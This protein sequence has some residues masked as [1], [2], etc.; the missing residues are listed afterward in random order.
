MN[1]CLE[2]LTYYFIDDKHF[3]LHSVYYKFK[4]GPYL[5]SFFTFFFRTIT[6]RTITTVKY[7]QCTI[8]LSVFKFR[9]LCF[10]LYNNPIQTGRS[11][12]L[13]LKAYNFFR[14]PLHQTL[15]KFATLSKI[16]LGITWRERLLCCHF[17]TFRKKKNE[18]QGGGSKMAAV[19]TSCCNCHER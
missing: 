11:A 8:Y 5:L 19:L 16:Y 7:Q 10:F 9:K 14:I 3:D 13:I 6:E 18:I 1:P 12:V 2:W 15:L 4:P 17:Q